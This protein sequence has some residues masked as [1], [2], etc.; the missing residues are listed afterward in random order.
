[1][2]IDY[3]REQAQAQLESIKEM[4]ARLEH[5]QECDG[6]DVD[7][8]ELLNETDCPFGQPKLKCPEQ[9]AGC[10]EELKEAIEAG[11]TPCDV[12]GMPASWHESEQDEF[13][14]YH[15][16]DAA[17]QAINEDPLSV[18]VRSSWQSQGEELEPAEYMILLC[19]GGPAARIIGDLNQHGGA[20]S[21]RLEY[22]DWGTPWTEYFEDGAGSTL[23]DYAN[24]FLR[25]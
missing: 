14:D 6:D 10:Y 1:M 24:Y 5:A 8:C 18:E 16:E 23:L 7:T 25:L 17:K 15:D 13:D 2:V 3:A 21:A 19:T 4:L 9:D 11:E 20:G 22:Q 12:C